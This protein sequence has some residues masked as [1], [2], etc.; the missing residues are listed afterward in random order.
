MLT[1]QEGEAQRR[2]W[3]LSASS[4]RDIN[5]EG[6]KDRG[7]LLLRD[8]TLTGISGG[9]NYG[10]DDRKHEFIQPSAAGH[11]SPALYV[12][13]GNRLI[14]GDGGVESPR[15]Q[16][17]AT[18]A[19]HCEEVVDVEDEDGLSAGDRSQGGNS[20]RAGC[21]EKD[22]G[23]HG[24]GMV[25][26]EQSEGRIKCE[27]S[28]GKEGQIDEVEREAPR[29][30]THRTV[31]P[32][33]FHES[34]TNNC[35]EVSHDADG[36]I[37]LSTTQSWKEHSSFRKNLQYQKLSSGK[38]TSGHTPKTSTIG[39]PNRHTGQQGRKAD[40]GADSNESWS[41]S[42]EDTYGSEV[43]KADWPARR[44]SPPAPATRRGGELDDWAGSEAYG[45]DDDCT[46]Y[47]QHERAS[48][49][50]KSVQAVTGTASSNCGGGGGDRTLVAA[51][52]R[53]GGG[54]GGESLA[55]ERATPIGTLDMKHYNDD[56][57][58]FAGRKKRED[59]V[60]V[61]PSL[62]K[63][64]HKGLALNNSTARGGSG[65]KKLSKITEARHLARHVSRE[66]DQ[67]RSAPHLYTNTGSLIVGRGSL[68][69]GCCKYSKG[70]RAIVA[71]HCTDLLEKSEVKALPQDDD[72]G[73]HRCAARERGRL[74]ANDP[75][76]RSA[77]LRPERRHRG[78]IIHKDS[79]SHRYDENHARSGTNIMNSSSSDVGDGCEAWVEK[80]FL[81][82]LEA[83]RQ[84]T[85]QQDE[86]GEQDRLPVVPL[87][88]IVG[89]G[90]RSVAGMKF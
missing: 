41:S 7:T 53:R 55:S 14:R 60:P 25:D 89:R 22:R 70:R 36:S 19:D 28:K 3:E 64:I 15:I 49:R 85:L 29:Y 44:I 59:V 54:R 1:T 83:A 57:H 46:A 23:G 63:I 71:N 61:V 37:L 21:D 45:S 77:S 40:T 42:E 39:G 88:V 68:K 20:V 34:K 76:L 82:R 2:N 75:L 4:A 18:C 69:H 27:K 8:N 62:N 56:R 16:F 43:G 9:S 51:G 48:I 33:T 11:L 74:E 31:L 35:A 13:V 66:N 5:S 73:R 32:S 24:D 17:L 72:D 65:N 38:N 30:S 6:D 80:E 81:S 12:D 86:A 47:D 52:G 87:P 58:S 78:G 84:E 90:N 79:S 50:L 26:G 10:I 67:P